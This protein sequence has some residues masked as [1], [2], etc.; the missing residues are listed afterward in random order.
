MMSMSVASSRSSTISPEI[1]CDALTTAATSSACA[2]E[3]VP[4]VER[5][6]V[7]VRV[8]ACDASHARARQL[9]SF[10]CAPQKSQAWSARSR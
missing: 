8:P 6:V 7:V 1:A 3:V 9:V 5:A 2:L 4:V 10:A